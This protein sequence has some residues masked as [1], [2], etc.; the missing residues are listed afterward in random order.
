M[1]GDSVE[2]EP[3]YMGYRDTETSIEVLAYEM[4]CLCWYK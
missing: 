3:V 4:N 1:Y 2:V